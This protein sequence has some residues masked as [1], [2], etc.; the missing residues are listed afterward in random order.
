MSEEMVKT[1]MTPPSVM[2]ANT[3]YPLFECVSATSCTSD[4]EHEDKDNCQPQTLKDYKTVA[5]IN[6]CLIILIG[7]LG[8]LF[9]I[10]AICVCRIRFDTTL[11]KLFTYI[12]Y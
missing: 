11:H 3:S 2:I 5:I 1:N 10:I 9:T 12:I 7:G 8:N 4:V 6:I